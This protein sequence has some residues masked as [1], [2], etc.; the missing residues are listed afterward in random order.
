MGEVGIWSEVKNELWDDPDKMESVTSMMENAMKRHFEAHS[1]IE[2]I[3]GSDVWEDERQL[4]GLKGCWINTSHWHRTLIV[5]STDAL[6][7]A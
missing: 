5:E 4:R 1:E 3:E 7:P 6:R 2:R